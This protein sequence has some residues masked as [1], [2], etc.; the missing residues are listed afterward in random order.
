M[1]HFSIQQKA[2]SF[3]TQNTVPEI[4]LAFCEFYSKE[5]RDHNSLNVKQVYMRR[6]I[7]CKIFVTIISNITA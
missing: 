5:A 1:P 4:E 7:D 2:S 3:F 6:F